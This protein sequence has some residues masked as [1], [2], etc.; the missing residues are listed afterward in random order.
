IPSTT[1]RIS[2]LRSSERQTRHQTATLLSNGGFFVVS[3]ALPG[4][5]AAFFL[6]GLLSPPDRPAGSAAESQSRHS[7]P[8]VALF[9]H[10]APVLARLAP[11]AVLAAILPC[12][13]CFGVPGVPCRS[14][15]AYG[16]ASPAG[17]STA[18]SPC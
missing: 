6:A 18:P 17:R 9:P 5:W 4:I 14:V 3:A 2:A 11:I 12:P 1:H 8:L 16:S 7:Y 15:P 10:I 13:A